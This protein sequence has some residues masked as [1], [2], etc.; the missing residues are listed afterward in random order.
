MATDY[1]GS[2]FFPS[3]NSLLAKFDGKIEMRSLEQREKKQ[4]K[5][6]MLCH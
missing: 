5:E 6:V 2:L 4:G 1:N 3:G